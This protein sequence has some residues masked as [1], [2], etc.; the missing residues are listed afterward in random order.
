MAPLPASV[1]FTAAFEIACPG[2][3]LQRPIR[4]YD[5]QQDASGFGLPGGQEVMD[6]YQSQ[7]DLDADELF[8]QWCIP[9]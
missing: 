3:R 5:A 2:A 7:N 8:R 6:A 4:P 9:S 1:T